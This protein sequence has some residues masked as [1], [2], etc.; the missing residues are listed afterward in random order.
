[1]SNLKTLY[2]NERQ[3]GN[4]GKEQNNT[5]CFKKTI[6]Y[7]S[8]VFSLCAALAICLLPALL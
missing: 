1:M 6:D 4:N 7:N 8:V 2:K 5:E 3:R